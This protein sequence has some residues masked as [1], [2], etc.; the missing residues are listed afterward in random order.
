[1]ARTLLLCLGF[2]K[3]KGSNRI[4]SQCTGANKRSK[5]IRF[6]TLLAICNAMKMLEGIDDSKP[7]LLLKN[8]QNA[9]GIKNRL[10]IS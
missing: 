10:Q 3:N 8:H 9:Q 1:M 6:E 4:H 5:S 2:E 7:Q